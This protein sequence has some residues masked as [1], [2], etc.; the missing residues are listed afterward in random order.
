LTDQ[1]EGSTPESA[2][3]PPSESTPAAAEPS[4]S[5][6]KMDNPLVP[7][8]GGGINT[9]R[10]T[11]R[12][13]ALYGLLG[14]VLVGAIV[15][16]VVLV[17]QPARTA[18]PAWSTWKPSGGNVGTVTKQIADHHASRYRMSEDGGQLVAVI[19]SG[20]QITSGTQNVP[21]KAIAVRKAPQSNQGVR[22]L[23]SSNTNT[24]V[25]TLCGLGANCSIEGGTASATRGRL[26]RRQ[27]LE[28]AL[29]TFKFA[30]S[31]DSILAFM[32]PPP[33]ETTAS[34]LLLEKDSLEEQLKQPLNKTLMHATPP[35]P[36]DADLAEAATID[37]LTLNKLFSYS[38]Q[39]LQTG[40][41]AIILDPA[42]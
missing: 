37:K 14:A 39:P 32:P 16:L 3:P 22:I 24:R 27:A 25:F 6:A 29:Y 10:Y 1:A 12:F 36:D 20:P 2:V 42:A 34:V 19:P 21:I 31:V 15:G 23:E 26:V 11:G 13:L 9:T 38:L 30:P 4:T 41:A 35:L 18:A 7:K 28:V 33:G 40:G 17:I 5:T 8:V